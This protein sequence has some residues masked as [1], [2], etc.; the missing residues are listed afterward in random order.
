MSEGKGNGAFEARL[1]AARQRAGLEKPGSAGPRGPGGP[2]SGSPLAIA[3]RVGVEMVSAL[4]VGVGIG[5]GLDR[6][7]GTAPVLLAVFTLLGGAAGVANVWRVV[8]PM[9]GPPS[10]GGE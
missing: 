9:G 1:R 3:L 8:G 5:W 7:L 4:I 6:W 10:A 2:L